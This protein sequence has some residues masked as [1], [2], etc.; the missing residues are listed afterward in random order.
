MKLGKRCKQCKSPVNTGTSRPA[1]RHSGR[2]QAT[3]QKFYCRFT[4]PEGRPRRFSCNSPAVP[5]QGRGNSAVDGIAPFSP[6]LLIKQHFLV[7]EGSFQGTATNFAAQQGK[8]AA[9]GASACL[10]LRVSHE[11]VI[12]ATRSTS[13]VRLRRCRVSFPVTC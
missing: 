5:L 10:A 3:V 1:Q 11:N 13:A 12:C 2:V 6:K 4:S 7:R 9:P 8:Y